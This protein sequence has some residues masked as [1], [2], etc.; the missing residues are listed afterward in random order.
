MINLLSVEIN[1]SFHS[2]RSNGPAGPQLISF[3]YHLDHFCIDHPSSARTEDVA[4]PREV[5]VVCF[6]GQFLELPGQS[7]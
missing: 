5:R 1:G 2:I 7:E 6:G 4:Q 3:V